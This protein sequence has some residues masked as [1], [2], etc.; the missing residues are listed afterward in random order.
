MRKSL[1]NKRNELNEENIK[2]I[3]NL[4]NNFQD[5]DNIKI[6]DN[7]DFGYTKVTVERPQQLNFKV[8]EERLENLYS[9]PAFNKL[10]TS[11][12]KNPKEKEKE[13]KEGKQQQNKIINSLKNIPN[14]L[15]KSY[16]EFD[17]LVT[18]EIGRFNIITPTFK[19]NIIEKLSKHD[20]TAEY[21]KDSK[22]KLKPDPNLR[23][24]EKIPLKTNIEQYF[25][26]EVKKY[27]NNA[28]MDRKKDKIGYEINFTRYFYKYE[29]PRPLEEIER[30]IKKITNEIQELLNENFENT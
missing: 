9:I 2:S 25:K 6:F 14:N 29:P 16:N 4:F 8:D 5:T 15:I 17:E 11:K 1:G 12:K 20:D 28:W 13:E 19:R 7:E 21:V 24:T 27:Y 22:G 30:D 23:D 26:E 18:D 10:I 3:I